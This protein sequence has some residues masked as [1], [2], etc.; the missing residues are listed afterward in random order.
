M[1]TDKN[2]N[3]E[4]VRAKKEMDKAIRS[5]F[6]A[7]RKKLMSDAIKRGIAVAKAKKQ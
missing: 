5:Y 1:N 2:Y 6:E 7:C 4:F 3:Q